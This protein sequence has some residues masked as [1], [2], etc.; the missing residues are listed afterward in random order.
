MAK[1]VH[2][3]LT[4]SLFKNGYKTKDSQPDISGSCTLAGV[5]YK[6][7]GWKET[8][9]NGHKKVFL[10]FTED[11]DEDFQTTSNNAKVNIN[12]EILF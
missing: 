11:T 4:G 3:E 1:F 12:D 10:K 6:I 8:T 7:A 9:K 2:N 5:K